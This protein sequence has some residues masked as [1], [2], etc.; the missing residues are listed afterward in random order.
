MMTLRMRCLPYRKPWR[1]FAKRPELTQEGNLG[2]EAGL[3]LPECSRANGPS[4]VP[5]T[6][7][8]FAGSAST[9][10]ARFPGT[11]GAVPEQPSLLFRVPGTGPRGVSRG[12]HLSRPLDDSGRPPRGKP[13]EGGALASPADRLTSP[14]MNVNALCLRWGFRNQ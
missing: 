9:Y 8:H 5:G 3:R 7:A 1:S 2:E 12:V 13:P 10:P 6:V 4:L 11:S 14:S